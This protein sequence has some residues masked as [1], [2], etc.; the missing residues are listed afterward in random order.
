MGWDRGVDDDRYLQGRHREQ[1]E[2]WESLSH[3]TTT[4]LQPSQALYTHPSVFL[5]Q[6]LIVDSFQ[7]RGG[8]GIL[9]KKLGPCV[10]IVK[11]HKEEETRA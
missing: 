7:C 4:Q 10:F 6:N 5:I 1:G 8:T 9:H 2:F 3:R 11:L